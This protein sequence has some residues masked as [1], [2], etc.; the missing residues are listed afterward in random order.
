MKKKIFISTILEAD[1]KTDIIEEVIKSDFEIGL[2]YFTFDMT[3]KSQRKLRKIRRKF[4]N[5]K[6][7]IFIH[8]WLIWNQ[9]V[10]K[11]Q[12]IIKN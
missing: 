9:Q 2:E 5:A 6:N 3:S 7:T 1:F 8:R 11:V 4:P 10:K 12:K